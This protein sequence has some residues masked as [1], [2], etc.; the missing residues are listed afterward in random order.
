MTSVRID[1]D[2][3]CDLK[4]LHIKTIVSRCFTSTCGRDRPGNRLTLRP[5]IGKIVI[6]P[7]P[8]LKYSITQ[9]HL[10]YC[11]H[12]NRWRGWF[13]GPHPSEPWEN[14]NIPVKCHLCSLILGMW[15]IK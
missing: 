4:I 11:S 15:G 14:F 12:L 8:L 3:D 10:S 6:N 7:I 13:F 5:K 2:N 1:N 9:N